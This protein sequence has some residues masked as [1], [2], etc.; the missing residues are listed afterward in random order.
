MFEIIKNIKSFSREEILLKVRP[1]RR[2]GRQLHLTVNVLQDVL[3]LYCQNNYFF[4]L[5]QKTSEEFLT[6]RYRSHFHKKLTG[7]YASQTDLLNLSVFYGEMIEFQLKRH[8][9]YAE[10]ILTSNY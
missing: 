5:H 4:S 3:L 8:L 7:A 2:K 9:A 10:Y 1:N 6:G